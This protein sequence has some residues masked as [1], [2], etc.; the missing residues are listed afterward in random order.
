MKSLNDNPTSTKSLN[1]GVLT[2][3][4]IEYLKSEG[5]EYFKNDSYTLNK[6]MLYDDSIVR[7]EVCLQKYIGICDCYAITAYVYEQGIGIDF[8]YDCGGNAYTKYWSFK[9]NTVEDA[10]DQMVDAIN[11]SRIN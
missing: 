7:E 1:H 4:I 5:F 8:D 3:S 6:A 11:E 2:K 10:Y 9:H